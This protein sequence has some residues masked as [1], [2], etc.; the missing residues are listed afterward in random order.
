MRDM[1]D[2]HNI[3]ND[4]NKLKLWSEINRMQF[5]ARN[6]KILLLTADNQ[7]HGNKMKNSLLQNSV[8]NVH[9]KKS[10]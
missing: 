5:N 1:E 6:Y 2:R 8:E 7:L 9:G 3:Q 10:G 4:L